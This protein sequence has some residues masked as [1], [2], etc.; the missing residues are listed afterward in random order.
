MTLL[1]TG[2]ESSNSI[3]SKHDFE[4]VVKE[5]GHW[6]YNLE[7]SPFCIIAVCLLKQCRRSCKK[8][9]YRRIFKTLVLMMN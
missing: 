9:D 3:N 8:T 5:S 2:K 7:A 6:S 1:V 4:N